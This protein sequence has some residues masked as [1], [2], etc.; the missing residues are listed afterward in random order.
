MVHAMEADLLPQ[1]ARASLFV[2]LLLVLASAP[3]L[4]ERAALR[5]PHH[6]PSPQLQTA[7]TPVTPPHLTYCGGKVLSQAQLVAVLWG[8]PDALQPSASCTS[9]LASCLRAWF[10]AFVASPQFNWLDEYQ[11]TVTGPDGNPGTG[12]HIGAPSFAGVFQITPANTASKVGQSEIEAE[13][14]AQ[15]QNHVLP[16]PNAADETIYEVFFPLTVDPSDNGFQACQDFCAYH[17]SWHAS[18]LGT[19]G[20]I[21]IMPSGMPPGYSGGRDCSKCG[22]RNDWFANLSGSIAHETVEAITDPFPG[23][24]CGSPTGWLDTAQADA[25][26]NHGE[27]GDACEGLPDTHLSAQITEVSFSDPADAGYVYVVQREW[28][29]H[30]SACLG[31]VDDAFTVS[32]P[33]QEVLGAPGGSTDV[34]ITTSTAVDAGTPLMVKLA[35][36][37]LPSYATATFNPATVSAGQ[38]STLSLALAAGAPT[39]GFSFGIT[40][41]TGSSQA[42]TVLSVGTADFSATLSPQTTIALTAGG[43]AAT[44]TLSTQLLSGNARGFT[45]RTTG[46]AGVTIS[47][48][49]GQLGTPLTLSLS[50]AA[51]APSAS[52]SL[53]LT[54]TSAGV[55]HTTSI[56]L[57]ISGDDATLA[58]P[59]GLTVAQGGT[60]KFT[61]TSATKAGNP[62]ALTL[63][64][65][66]L[67]TGATATFSPAQI[68]S[69]QSATLTLSVP[70]TQPLAPFTFTIV[71]T[72]PI[73]P[74]SLAAPV[75]VVAP[76]SGCAQTDALSLALLGLL[77]L[78]VRK[79]AR[80]P[81]A[82]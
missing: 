39:S 77:V 31:T 7:S 57:E 1:T 23:G 71:G 62:Q 3:T 58:V 34:T 50:A 11:T 28:S 78:G 60:T 46:A 5:G 47:P 29:N 61:V 51:G 35:A 38:T 24:S 45:L 48:T 66:H 14:V 15:I 37:G 44:A 18:A 73:A 59:D 6:A 4:A 68:T 22:E 80:P 53:S 13:L 52:S 10:P 30:Y 36:H 40:G 25:M 8:P 33:A 55:T 32:G 27:I 54:V 16:A 17:D 65:T 69:G 56:P 64:S 26:S 72:G 82:V 41:E 12:Q 75:T 63:S 20:I 74:I 67:P 49:T 19:N 70:A 2:S 21:A 42:Q 79:R 81:S 9:D 43:A 76:P